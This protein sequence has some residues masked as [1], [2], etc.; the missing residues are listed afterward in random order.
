MRPRALPRSESVDFD[1]FMMPMIPFNAWNPFLAGAVTWN[2]QAHEGFAMLGLE[3]QDFLARRFKQDL[4]L[5]QRLAAAKSPGEI[6]AA[7]VEFWLRAY[8]DYA[9]EYT[10]V[11]KPASGASKKAIAATQSAAEEAAKEVVPRAA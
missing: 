1:P 4:A 10:T 7:Y 8:D 11:M 5:L 6:W 9:K 3:W 2:S